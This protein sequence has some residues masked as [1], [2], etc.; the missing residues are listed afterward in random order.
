MRASVLTAC[1][2]RLH[3]FQ[4]PWAA[5]L[6]R[7]VEVGQDLALGHQRDHLVHV[8]IGI[9]VVQP[10]P[11]ADLAEL[12]REVDES[13]PDL[14]A[15]PGLRAVFEVGAVRARVLGNDEKLADACIAQ[16]DRLVQD[17]VDRAAHEVAAHRRD[18]AEAA[19]VIAAFRDLEVSVVPR[20]QSH[21]LRRHEVH[22]RVVPG[23]QVL[24][25]GADD[26][27]VGVRAGDLE[28]R[29]MPL[30]DLLGLR[31]EAAGH[32]HAAVLRERLAD[33]V[34][35][36]VHRVV[37]EAAGIDDDEVRRF[38]VRRDVVAL[39]AQLREDA[40]GVHER[41]G[42]AEAHEADAGILAGHGAF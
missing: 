22:E 40:L 37:D 23:R 3:E 4:D 36:L 38:V 1:A 32:D 8:R 14:P 28:D 26:F 41:L 6:E 5:V 34:E 10:H 33:G 12:P 9:H 29:G 17:L 11:G 42:A 35:R 27:F 31:T 24:M 2:G 25:N 16:A 7:H 13:A 15:A 20:R 39:G 30:R 21:A 19:A 18:D